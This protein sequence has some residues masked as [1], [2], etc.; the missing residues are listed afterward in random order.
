MNKTTVVPW[1]DITDTDATLDMTVMP[2]PHEINPIYKTEDYVHCAKCHGYGGW[3]LRVNAYGPGQH[4][5][6]FCEQCGGKGWVRKDH[7]SANCAHASIELSR[8][9]CSKRNLTH[10]G[11]C[12][13]T[14]ECQ[15]CGHISGY[16]SSD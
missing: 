7:P 11:R 3:H 5:N 9:E 16:D 12:W 1:L 2:N 4:F 14:T 13:H 6:C 15:K 8:E 10:Y